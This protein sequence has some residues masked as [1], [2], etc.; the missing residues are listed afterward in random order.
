MKKWSQKIDYAHI[1]ILIYP[2]NS[3]EMRVKIYAL[4]R[5]IGGS[6]PQRDGETNVVEAC[7]K[8]KMKK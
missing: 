6:L 5:I 7:A 1:Y 2:Q 3:T 8:V 4:K